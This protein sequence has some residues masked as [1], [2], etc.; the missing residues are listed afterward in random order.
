MYT[1]WRNC[2]LPEHHDEESKSFRFRYGEQS[3]S[4]KE[5]RKLAK[6]EGLSATYG[7]GETKEGD[8]YQQVADTF[9]QADQDAITNPE[10]VC[11]SCLNKDQEV[12]VFYFWSILR[13]CFIVY[14]EGL[15][16]EYFSED[17]VKVDYPTAE[18]VGEG[19]LKPEDFLWR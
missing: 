14:T 15:M 9:Y 11:V 19:N 8:F 17:S 4:Y 2:K 16:H 5:T 6:A 7:S 18:W 10:A 13:K 1:D 3:G 12:K